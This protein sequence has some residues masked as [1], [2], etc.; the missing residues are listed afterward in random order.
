MPAVARDSKWR[1]V[2]PEDLCYESLN[3]GTTRRRGAAVPVE[4]GPARG[5][6]DQPERAGKEGGQEKAFGG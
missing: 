1:G 5:K 6:P 4:A 2:R 3:F